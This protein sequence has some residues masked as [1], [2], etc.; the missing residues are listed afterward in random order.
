MLEIRKGL[1]QE[2]DVSIYAFTKLHSS[3]MKE[4]RLKLLKEKKKNN[5]K[6]TK[7]KTFV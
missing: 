5:K 4:I 6:I 1:E 3:T 7:T 2:L